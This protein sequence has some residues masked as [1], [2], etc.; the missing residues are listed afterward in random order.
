MTYTSDIHD[1]I[2]MIED[3]QQANLTLAEAANRLHQK[4]NIPFDK[5]WPAIMKIQQLSE[6]EAM[7]L[8]KEWCTRWDDD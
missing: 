1:I 5:I 3:I 6:K 2:S 8:T 7:S 4:E